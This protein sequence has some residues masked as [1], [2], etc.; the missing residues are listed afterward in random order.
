MPEPTTALVDVARL[1]FDPMNPRFMADADV[2]KDDDRSVIRHL[3]EHV[4]LRE[5]ILSI[6]TNGYINIEPLVGLPVP[7][8]D[9][10]YVLEGNR[11][12]AALKVIGSQE[13]QRDF[14]VKLP[15]IDEGKRHT[16]N[17]V[18]IYLVKD[19]RDARS[20]I[21]FKHINGPY[22]WDALAKAT[23]AKEWLRDAPD[24]SIDDIAQR[25]GDNHRTVARQLLGL[26]TLEQARDNGFRDE[27]RLGGKRLAFSHLYTAMAR[28]NFRKYLG[29]SEQDSDDDLKPNPV[30]ADHLSQLHNVMTWLYGS[31]S[32][33]VRAVVVSQN[34]DLNRLN[35]VLGSPV[36]TKIL[37][38]EK[39]LDNA[40]QASTPAIDRFSSAL[41]QASRSVQDA[42]AS[43]GG[44]DGDAALLDTAKLL[45]ANARALYDAMRSH[46]S[47]ST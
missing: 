34:P 17:K 39:N 23:F 5:L 3:L 22:R 41:V 35:N 10:F 44:Y 43:V 29:L 33:H 26:Y 27:D 46:N 13:L 30:P 36:G 16:F 18:S 12:L 2:R 7:H 25:L 11:R 4:D 32:E 37:E 31:R 45:A 20:F 6:A 42:L 8:S 47:A 24:T 21:G 19:R 38:E 40:E 28:P 9:D 15:A 1:R 14:A